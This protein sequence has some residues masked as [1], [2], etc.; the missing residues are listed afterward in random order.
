[1]SKGILFVQIK[2]V[3]LLQREMIAKIVKMHQFFNS[4]PQPLYI[5]ITHLWVK[6]I[7]ISSIEGQCLFPRGDCSKKS[8]DTMTTSEI[9][10]PE[11]RGLFQSNLAK[12]NPPWVIRESG[13]RNRSKS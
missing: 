6:G 10:F 11:P 5:I 2:G 4:T 13:L 12:K 1:M 9:S 7:E 3:T 8:E